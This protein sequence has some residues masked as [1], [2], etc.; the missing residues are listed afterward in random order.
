MQIEQILKPEQWVVTMSTHISYEHL[1]Q[2][3]G[4]AFAELSNYLLKNDA[5]L[6]GTP[7]ISYMNL[8]ENGQ[9]KDELQFVE[10]GFPVER[11]LPSTP[12]FQ[13]YLQ[14]PYHA[15]R[16]VFIGDYDVLTEP[17]QELL[18][19]I[20]E[21]NGVFG[22]RSYEYFLTDTSV[23]LEQQETMIELAYMPKDRE[24]DSE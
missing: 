8:D 10:I 14:E 23:P 5:Q 16:T 18:K 22:Q 20:K 21:I 2:Y 17:Y 9:A 11:L 3:I 4:N 7:F 1:P 6:V 24:R 15:V 13:A 12:K 19:A